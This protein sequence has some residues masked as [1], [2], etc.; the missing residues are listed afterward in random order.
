LQDKGEKRRMGTLLV[1]MDEGVANNEPLIA[2]PINL[3]VLLELPQDQAYVGFTASTGSKWE[4]HDI[5][6][7][8]WCDR[9]PCDSTSVAEFDYNQV[10]R[11]PPTSLIS[12]ADPLDPRRKASS[13]RLLI[14]R[15]TSRM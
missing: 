4:K 6:S 8:I 9:I 15:F 14:T 1:F 2:I 12:R 11:A 7:W 3:S 10:G 5:L 13:L